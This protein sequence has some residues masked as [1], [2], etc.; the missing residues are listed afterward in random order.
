MARYCLIPS[1]IA[2]SCV[3]FCWRTVLLLSY[4]FAGTYSHAAPPLM[5][6]NVYRPGIAL[7]NY[8]VSEKYDGVR[9]Y[10]NGQKFY[11]RN[12]NII[13]APHWFTKDWPD[14]PMDGELW[15]GRGRFVQASTAVRQLVPDDVVWKDLRFMVFDLP[16]ERGDFAQRYG[17]MQKRL[18]NFRCAYLEVVR[19]DRIASH[20]ALMQQLDQVVKAGGEGLMLHHMKSLYRAERSDDLL[21]VKTHEDAEARVVAHL[22]GKGKYT[23]RLGALLVETPQG[24]RFRIGSGF[25]DAE[26]QNP[27]PIGS[28]I[29]YRYR[30]LHQS[31]IPRFASFLRSRDQL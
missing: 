22:P 19:Q 24:L 9:A 26:R 7:D 30:G 29:T 11:T 12:G 2:S 23:G 21:K 27:P 3:I 13:H 6:A 17:L 15:A 18:G 16:A 25:S 14:Y 8:F 31:G 20:Q 10:W 5:L 4:F 28:V 1:V